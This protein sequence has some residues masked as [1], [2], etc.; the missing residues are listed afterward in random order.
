MP[1]P[2]Q[3]ALEQWHEFLNSRNPEI[4]TDLLAE[5][6]VFYSPVVFTPQ[7]GKWM[8]QLY[9]M[10]ALQVLGSNEAHFEYTNKLLGDKQ[11]VLEFTAQLDGITI[12]GVDM[13]E[14][15]DEGKIIKF[16]VMVR[17]LKAINK[18]HEKMGAML[19]QLKA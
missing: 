18:I 2:I 15:N 14:V 3:T 10:G 9:L 1:T 16:K 13:I 6:V 17:P 8:A 12:N 7:K 19:A 5:E 4:L 11:C